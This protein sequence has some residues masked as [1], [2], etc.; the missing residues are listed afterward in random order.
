MAVFLKQS[1][2]NARAYIICRVGISNSDYFEKPSESSLRSENN[3]FLRSKFNVA[4]LTALFSLCFPIPGYSDVIENG[5]DGI[6]FGSGGAGGVSVG[7]GGNGGNGG[8][9]PDLG[10]S[11]GGGGAGGG[12]PSALDGAGGQ[13]GTGGPT[14]GIGGNGGASTGENG[15]PGGYGGADGAGGGGGGHAG[16]VTNG[17]ILVSSST[18]GS[19]GSGG[20]GGISGGGGGGGGV[21]L[22]VNLGASVTEVQAEM[23]AQVS[24]VV[25]LM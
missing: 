15:A 12:S 18:G 5:G 25:L 22:I 8:A 3:G 14:G 19:G 4:L 17:G 11:G 24:S 2:R 13:G 20:H 10:V 6:F 21:G 7:G 1:L 23:V 16:Q 9:N